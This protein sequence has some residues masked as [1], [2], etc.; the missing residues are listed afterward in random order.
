MIT[1]CRFQ[2]CMRRIYCKKYTDMDSSLDKRRLARS[3]R[4]Q[5]GAS[6]HAFGAGLHVFPKD[7]GRIAAFWQEELQVRGMLKRSNGWVCL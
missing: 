3:Y 7:C 5:P 2:C 6:V 4:L 1:L